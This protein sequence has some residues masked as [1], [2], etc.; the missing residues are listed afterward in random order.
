MDK[1]KVI[2]AL[3]A[4]AVLFSLVIV[5]RSCSRGEPNV[6]KAEWLC[7][8]CGA[9]YTF[10][11]KELETHYTENYGEPL[12]CPDCGGTHVGPARSCPHCEKPYLLRYPGEDCPHCG[13]PLPPPNER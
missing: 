9:T 8:D 5:K 1:E 2:L 12:T 13:E 7:E 10:T 4:A 6:T 11:Q 3:C